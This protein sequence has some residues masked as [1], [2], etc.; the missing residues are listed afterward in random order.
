MGSLGTDGHPRRIRGVETG[1]STTVRILRLTRGKDGIGETFVSAAKPGGAFESR[2]SA[3]PARAN[4]PRTLA[5]G[6]VVD[7]PRHPSGRV[8]GSVSGGKVE[9]QLGNRVRGRVLVIHQ[10]DLGHHHMAWLDQRADQ[11]IAHIAQTGIDHRS[12]QCQGLSGSRG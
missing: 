2:P 12:E 8:G 3:F 11:S 1:L 5:L 9:A 6:D 7:G 4:D 10:C